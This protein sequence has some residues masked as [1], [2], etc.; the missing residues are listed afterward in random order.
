MLHT[1]INILDELDNVSKIHTLERE[2]IEKMMIDF[3]QRILVTMRIERMSV[4]LFNKENT[5]IISMG[6]YD[7]RTHQFS[8]NK[9][10]FKAKYPK[11]FEAINENRIL[12]IENTMSHKA[13]GEL[14]HDYLIPNNIVSLA[15]VPIRI[16]GGI[17]GI[18][19][20]EKTDVTKIFDEK[21]LTFAF[22]LATVFGSN[23]EA[24]YRRAVQHQLK[25][26]MEEKELLIQEINHRVKNNFSI[27][28]GLLR[29]SKQKTKSIE[30]QVVFEEFEKRI[31]SMLKIH[32]L[33]YKTKN[34][35]G[36][37]LSVYLKELVDEFKYSHSEIENR[38][39]VIITDSN[40]LLPTKTAIHVG[41]IVTEIFI[42]SIKYALPGTKN[43][44]F[45]LMLNLGDRNALK[46]IIGDNGKGF[47]FLK[48]LEK[49]SLGLHLIKDL[50]ND[51]DLKFTFPDGVHSYYEFIFNK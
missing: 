34:Y 5:A 20:F 40:Y 29:I 36:I 11:Y 48:N 8:K 17:V 25:T 21:E 9:M 6:E 51:A 16:E 18:M 35:T 7:L 41:L 28:I 14:K 2:D 19:C 10:L 43:F 3:A 32:E 1:P 42:N 31:F 44:Q 15:D 49:N 24:R 46:L 38:L 23:L 26:A 33:L 39:T 30:Q 4:W 37:N 22:S 27:L 13:T 50:A 45:K 47:D 12:V